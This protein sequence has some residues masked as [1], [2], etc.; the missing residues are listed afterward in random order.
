MDDDFTFGGKYRLEEEI[1]RRGVRKYLVFISRKY[2]AFRPPASC[3]G[4]VSLCLSSSIH[5]PLF[6]TNANE[7][8]FVL[9]TT[10]GPSDPK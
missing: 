9:S 7:P 4:D 5:R 2:N 8:S 3:T 6:A 1:A 10:M